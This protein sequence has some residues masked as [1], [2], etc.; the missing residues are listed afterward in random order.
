MRLGCI[1]PFLMIELNSVC[2]CY[3]LTRFTLSIDL[4]GSSTLFPLKCDRV[5]IIFEEFGIIKKNS[6]ENDI[7]LLFIS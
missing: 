5:K 2:E 4:E 3:P 7:C 6:V 1:D